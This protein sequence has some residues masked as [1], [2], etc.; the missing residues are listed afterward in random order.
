MV[1]DVGGRRQ[2]PACASAE[3]RPFVALPPVPVL[4]N[5]HAPSAAAARAAPRGS[6][7]LGICPNCALIH[8]L[9]FDP[10][11]VRYTTDYEASLHYSPRFQRYAEELAA[12]LVARHRLA[13]R[14]LVEIG[15]G[16][17]EFLSLL[18]RAGAGP[19]IGFDASYEGEPAAEAGVRVHKAFYTPAAFRELRADLLVCRHVLEHLPEPAPFLTGL[20]E[21]VPVGGAAY[22]EVPDGLYTLR[23]LGIWDLIYEHCSYFVAPAVV[24]LLARTGFAPVAMASAFGGQFLS[25][26]AHRQTPGPAAAA[27]AEVEYVLALADR[28]AAEFRAKLAHWTEHVGARLDA[29]RRLAVW[30]AGSK[31]VTFL[32]LVGPANGID[33]VVDV[34]VRKQG[35]HV[36]GTGQRIRAPTEL[37]AR[38]LDDV[39]VMNPNYA[40]EIRQTLQE[41]GLAPELHL[42]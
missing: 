23:D 16:K 14:T 11:L 26:H 20:R 40:A 28:F 42:V 12:A 39:Y 8:N 17:G 24:R 6:I 9:D 3:L 30:G 36:A 19:C 33:A 38:A 27:G 18:A 21:L 34:N 7:R 35:R 32:N 25:I 2:C 13:G 22:F 1:A 5:V 29:G 10:A 41:L 4:C 15:C 31:G 37:A